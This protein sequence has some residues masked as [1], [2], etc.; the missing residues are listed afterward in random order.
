MI[1]RYKVNNNDSEGGDDDDDHHHDHDE[2]H[3]HDDNG[4]SNDTPYSVPLKTKK[5]SAHLTKC[6]YN[7]A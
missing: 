3:H 6:V 1:V 5:K 7:M 4:N 2:D